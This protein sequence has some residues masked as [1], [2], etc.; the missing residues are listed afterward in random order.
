MK[1]QN[2]I[3]ICYL[4]PPRTH[5]SLFPLTHIFLLSASL[6]YFSFIDNIIQEN[7]KCNFFFTFPNDSESVNTLI[8]SF[9]SISTIIKLQL[10]QVCKSNYFISDNITLCLPFSSLCPPPSTHSQAFPTGLLYPGVMR[11]C[12]CSLVNIFSS[13]LLPSPLD[14][15]FCLHIQASGPILFC[16]LNSICKCDHFTHYG[17]YTYAHRHRY[18]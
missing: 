13:P 11:T 3:T 6:P 4:Y 5:I 7:I 17:H 2:R 10:T 18:T 8:H 1:I 14:L 12:I 15:S 9:F 16:S